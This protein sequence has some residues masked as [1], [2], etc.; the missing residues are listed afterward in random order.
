MRQAAAASNVKEQ[1]MAPA[2]ADSSALSLQLWRATGL[3]PKALHCPRHV[4]SSDAD[5]EPSTSTSGQHSDQFVFR[6][7]QLPPSA[8]RF[9]NGPID[10]L[11]TYQQGGQGG[12]QLSRRTSRATAPAPP[13]VQAVP[14][15]G[16]QPR[17]KPASGGRGAGAATASAS[18]GWYSEPYAAAPPASSPEVDDYDV[19]LAQCPRRPRTLRSRRPRQEVLLIW[20][21]AVRSVSLSGQKGSKSNLHQQPQQLPPGAAAETGLQAGGGS[22]GGGSVSSGTTSFGGVV[23]DA[24]GQPL[25]PSSP[26]SEWRG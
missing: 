1:R 9:Y 18:A 8:Q 6:V 24:K 4:F 14:G 10:T 19:L 2:P 5:C 16:K 12:L 7:P 20:A 25:S 13:P 11:P 23:L 21:D 22:S 17:S 26:L 3:A 15:A